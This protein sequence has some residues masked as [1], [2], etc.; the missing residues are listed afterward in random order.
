MDYVSTWIQQTLGLGPG[1]QVRIVSS[2]I[3]VVLLWIIHIVATKVLVARVEDVYVRYRTR[4]TTGYILFLIGIL[5]VGRIWVEGF[6]SLATY[7]GIL[8]AGLAVA[9]RDPLVNLAGWLF[10]IWRRPFEVG[11]RVQIGSHAGDVID[12]RIFAFTLMEIGNWVDADQSTGRVIHVPN[13][14]VFTETVANYSRGFQHIWNEIPVLITFESNWEKAKE[15]LARI[16][17][18][19]SEAASKAAAEKV[20]QAARK[21]MI[22]YKKLTPTVYTSVKES[23][24]H[25][26]I[27]YL[28]EPRRRRTTSEAIWEDI[29]REFATCDDIEFAYPTLRYFDNLQEGKPGARAA[30]PG[31]TAAPDS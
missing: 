13:G 1:P 2:I 26:T 19:H 17:A 6:S 20:R 18:G 27:R 11:D 15:I 21:Y 28:C 30:G 5:V 16:G 9:L 22:F 3:A 24:V 14:K 29:L 4:K 7:L 8:S 23:G 12:V 10:I 25:L 31:E